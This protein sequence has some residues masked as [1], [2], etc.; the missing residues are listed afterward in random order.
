MSEHPIPRDARDLSPEEAR[1]LHRAAFDCEL[2]IRAAIT[3]L[4]EDTWGLAERLYRFH[5]ERFW[6]VLGYGTL[7]EFL[8]QPEIGL[9]RSWYF[10]LVKAWRDLVVTRRVQ[11]AGLSGIEPSKVAEVLPA[12]MRG[13]ARPDDAL[14]DAKVLGKRDLRE[15][16]RPGAITRHGQAPDGSTPLAA[17]DEPERMQC[18][19]CGGWTTANALAEQTS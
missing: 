3:K 4:H 7:N 5:E 17:H 16:Y 19:A 10:V 13:D 1:A 12:I 8:A 6:E 15:K 14:S 2:E 18:P 11:P 9:R